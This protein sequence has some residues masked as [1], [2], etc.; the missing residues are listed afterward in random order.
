[1]KLSQHS[2]NI[3]NRL[4]AIKDSFNA[5]LND[6]FANAKR[7]HQVEGHGKAYFDALPRSVDDIYLVYDFHVYFEENGTKYHS[8]FASDFESLFENDIHW[9]FNI[10]SE[11]SMATTKERK[12]EELPPAE[13]LH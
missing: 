8:T 4:D 10:W 9:L 2:Q 3:Q 12:Q 7:D 6:W 1:M 5:R 11:G 13:Q